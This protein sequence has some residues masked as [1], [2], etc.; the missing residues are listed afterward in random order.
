MDGGR[1]TTNTREWPTSSPDAALQHLRSRWPGEMEVEFILTKAAQTTV[2]YGTESLAPKMQTWIRVLRRRTK[3]IVDW[4]DERP[5]FSFPPFTEA[6]AGERPPREPASLM[7]F[8]PERAIG[9][10]EAAVEMLARRA[11]ELNE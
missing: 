8:E 11:K 10:I 5:R 9:E 6:P 2:L 4:L 3:A 7:A 1:P